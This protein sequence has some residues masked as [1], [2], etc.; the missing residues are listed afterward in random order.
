LDNEFPE[1]IGKSQKIREIKE[2]ILYEINERTH[3][4]I[5]GEPGTGKELVAKA[6]WQKYHRR[7]QK[8]FIPYDCGAV[9]PN[10]IRSSL[11][12][13]RKGAFTGAI[14]DREGW[15]KQGEEGMVFLDE[16]ANLPLDGLRAL[17]RFVQFGEY[18]PVGSDEVLYSDTR[19]VAATNQDI[20]NAKRFPQ[21]L[22]GRFQE[23]IY[24][25]PLKERK[26]DIP[27]LVNSFLQF[28][29]RLE[30]MP[31]PLVLKTDLLDKLLEYNWPEN[32]RELEQSSANWPDALIP[33]E[34]FHLKKFRH[35]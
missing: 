28:F 22:K 35:G 5:L 19:I 2:Q 16:I 31:T 34:N 18:V 24:L 9:E 26:E 23:R 21:D 10:L 12:G 15:L 20:E 6:V 29:T 1:L 27:L 25:P 17:L 14:Q 11:F 30:K 4:L 3:V 13:H 8:K 7:R 32:V 33:A